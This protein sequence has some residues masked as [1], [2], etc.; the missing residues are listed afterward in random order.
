MFGCLQ[1]LVQQQQVHAIQDVSNILGQQGLSPPGSVNLPFGDALGVGTAESLLLQQ[2]G[3]GSGLAAPVIDSQAN[4]LLQGTT[5]QYPTAMDANA[6]AAISGPSLGQALQPS[7]FQSSDGTGAAWQVPETRQGLEGWSLA[8]AQTNPFLASGPPGVSPSIALTQAPATTSGGSSQFS[9]LFLQPADPSSVKA[10]TGAQP[11]VKSP[12]PVLSD[13]SQRSGGNVWGP[14]PSA[15]S[16]GASVTT[17]TLPV[18]QSL[19]ASLNTPLAQQRSLGVSS[20][21]SSFPTQ[22]KGMPFWT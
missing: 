19:F 14:L 3:L 16:V 1:A 5:M 8:Q 17:A 2:P 12:V 20:A 22:E 6:A 15:K 13:W 21:Y 9:S 11:S 7:P 18:G 10:A 4:P